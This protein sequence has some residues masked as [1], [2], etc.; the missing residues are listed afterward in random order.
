MKKI[1]TSINID[2]IL[3]DKLKAKAKKEK[4]SVSFV[5]NE[6]LKNYFKFRKGDT[7]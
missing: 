3:Y 6:I 7:K 5:L 4:R 2:T 1:T